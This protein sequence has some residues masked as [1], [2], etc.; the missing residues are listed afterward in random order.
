MS[1]QQNSLA[2]LLSQ[3]LAEQIRQTAILERIATQQTQLITALADDG[4]GDEP[5]AIA[6][7]YLSGAPVRHWP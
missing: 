6:Q 1:E 5:D 3:V 4:D 7:T 2:G